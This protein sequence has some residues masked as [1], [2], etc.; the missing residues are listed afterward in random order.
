[1]IL[2][3]KRRN[4][5]SFSRGT[6]DYKRMA[7]RRRM[8]VATEMSA[9][10]ASNSCG[11]PSRVGSEAPEIAAHPD[12]YPTSSATVFVQHNVRVWLTTVSRD[13]D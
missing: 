2:G 1:M 11:D 6:R 7:K 4:A 8:V 12:A 3:N 13:E 10:L 5:E 9:A